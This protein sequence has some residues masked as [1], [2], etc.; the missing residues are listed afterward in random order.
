MSKIQEFIKK[1]IE[2]HPE[3]KKEYD[4]LKPSY[5]K[6]LC[7]LTGE[8][9]ERYLHDMK[10]CQEYASLN[11]EIMADIILSNLLG[12]SLNKFG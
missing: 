6:S 3:L 9:R 7:Y 1:D 4:D 5:P 12:Q 10:I 11:R 8:Y 2:R